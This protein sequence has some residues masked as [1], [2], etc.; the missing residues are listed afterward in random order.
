MSKD[1]TKD[2]QGGEI[3]YTYLALMSSKLRV[4]IIGGGKAAFI[5]A[6]NF[7]SKGCYIEVL[8]KTFLNEFMKIESNN[9]VLNRKSYNK[10]FIEDK[11][12]I[13]LALDDEKLRSEVSIHCEEEFKIFID[14]SNFKEGM[15][16]VPVQRETSNISIALNTKV[17][18]PKGAMLVA[19]ATMKTINK[20]NDFIKYTGLIRNKVKDF[21]F[22]KKEIIDFINTEDFMFIWEKD[23][24][25]LVLKLFFGDDIV[26][27]LD[28]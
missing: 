2:I 23:K 5:K 22:N 16:V 9:I 25:E 1:T 6:K 27:K 20:Y 3:E 13:I 24:S 15:A 12:I 14:C 7:I 10:R 18:N 4:G 8:S 21:N 11:H 19:E 28:K 17:G 26:K